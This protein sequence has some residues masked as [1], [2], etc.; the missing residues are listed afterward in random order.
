MAWIP[1]TPHEMKFA[2]PLSDAEEEQF[3]QYA[4]GIDP[5][6]MAMWDYYHPV[7]REEW[8]KRGIKPAA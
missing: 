7:C 6:D 5:P 8:E 2:R 3:R 1:T 4:Q